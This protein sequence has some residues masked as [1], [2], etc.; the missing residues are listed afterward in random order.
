MSDKK[1][2]SRWDRLKLKLGIL[3]LGCKYCLF[4]EGKDVAFKS[5]QKLLEHMDSCKNNPDKLFEQTTRDR[6]ILSTLLEK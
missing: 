6:K 1:K 5:E 2:L 3:K 4:Y